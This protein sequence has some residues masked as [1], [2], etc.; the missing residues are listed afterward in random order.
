MNWEQRQIEAAKKGDLSALNDVVRSYYLEIFKYCFWQ[1][2]NKEQA[3]DITQET[4]YKAIRFLNAYKNNGSFRAFL[5]KIAHNTCID[6][7][8]RK[9]DISDVDMLEVIY[10]ESG[11]REI[12]DLMDFEKMLAS[13]N[14]KQ[15]ELFI[16][17][18]GQD[19]SFREIAEITGRKL[20]TVQTE[21]SRALRKIE[22]I[23]KGELTK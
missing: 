15:R 3:E 5:Y 22:K 4:F 2:K 13:L 6:Y 10:E 7:H 18:F 8:K 19:L 12:E 16:L 14:D 9:K 1:T 21:I 20:R 23:Q 11:F 17:R